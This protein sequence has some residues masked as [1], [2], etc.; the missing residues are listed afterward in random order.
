MAIFNIIWKRL[1]IM[2]PTESKQSHEMVRKRQY[3]ITLVKFHNPSLLIA[4]LLKFSGWVCHLQLKQSTLPTPTNALLSCWTRK[5]S[6]TLCPELN[7]CWGSVI[8]WILFYH[9]WT[10]YLSASIF[11]FC[12][13]DT[14][15]LSK[16]SWWKNHLHDIY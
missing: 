15:R 11:L 6:S 7:F 9:P 1:Y 5:M 4:S 12:S 13:K 10:Y 2:K 16:A 14:L 8:V 3:F